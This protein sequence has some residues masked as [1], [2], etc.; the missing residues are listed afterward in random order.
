LSATPRCFILNVT[1]AP[2]GARWEQNHEELYRY[3]NRVTGRASLNDAGPGSRI[4]YYA[5]S[6]SR[7][8]AKHFIAAATVSYIEPGWSGPWVVRLQDYDPLPTPV[9]VEELELEGWNRQ[10]AITEITFDTYRALLSAGGLA[11]EATGR[12]GD[13]PGREEAEVPD[14]GLGGGRVA[15]R[16]V[17]QYPIGD[18]IPALT[19]PGPVPGVL[20]G[21]LDLVPHYTETATGLVPDDPDAL[22]ARPRDPKRDKLAEQRAV[23]ITTRALNNAGWLLVAD[24]QKD[25]VGYDLEF[26]RHDDR[27][28]VEVKGIVGRRLAFNVTPKELWRARTDARWVLIAVTDV[29]TPKNAFELHVVTRDQVATADRTVTGYRLRL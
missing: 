14:V 22:P 6:K 11:V 17:R 21:G 7:H 4:V 26:T 28:N 27:L 25:G 23:D 20:D 10:H 1:D 13:V 19:V 8:D 18:D 15:E 3:N 29:L 9:T 2:V 5:T 12:P 24:R 16:I